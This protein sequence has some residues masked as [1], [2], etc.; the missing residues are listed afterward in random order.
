MNSLITLLAGVSALVVALHAINL[1]ATLNVKTWVGHRVE[2]VFVTAAESTIFA[3]A[4][5]V[6]AEGE[7][8]GKLLLIGVGILLFLKETR[9][10]YH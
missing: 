10:G 8:N 3:G 4:I 2:F 9:Y 1:A 6:A 7:L 5:W